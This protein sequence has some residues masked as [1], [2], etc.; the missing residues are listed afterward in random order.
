MQ[1][2]SQRLSLDSGCWWRGTIMHELMH[3]IG[4]YFSVAKYTKYALNC[5][6]CYDNAVF[7]LANEN[8]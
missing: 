8:S 4:I 7:Y 1:T 6:S 3:A 2:W 5:C